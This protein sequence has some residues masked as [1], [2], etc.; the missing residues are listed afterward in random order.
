VDGDSKGVSSRKGKYVG[1]GQDTGIEWNGVGVPVLEIG[2]EGEWE[3]K[4]RLRGK[5]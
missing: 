2:G 5:R 1:G 3:G 4:G